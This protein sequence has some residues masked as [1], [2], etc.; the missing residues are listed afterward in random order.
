MFANTL[1]GASPLLLFTM[2][3]LSHKLRSHKGVDARIYLTKGEHFMFSCTNYESEL[4]DASPEMSEYFNY[5]KL[6]FSKFPRE[7]GQFSLD[8]SDNYNVT[9]EPLLCS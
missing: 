5:C 7:S 2:K 4:F 8:S 1:G 9:I 6:L 3:F